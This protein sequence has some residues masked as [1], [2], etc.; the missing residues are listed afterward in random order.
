MRGTAPARPR[1]GQVVRGCRRGRWSRSGSA[2]ILLL[3]CPVSAWTPAPAALPV[4]TEIEIVPSVV[5][6]AKG[7]QATRFVLEARL[8]TLLWNKR[9]GIPESAGV[10]VSWSISP[11]GAG[12]HLI[13]NPHGYHAT[14]ELDPGVDLA[15]TVIVKAQA[16]GLGADSRIVPAGTPGEDLV[17]T[18]YT[19]DMAADAVVVRGVKGSQPC[20]MWLAPGLSR[21]GNAGDVTAN[22]DGDSWGVALLDPVHAVSMYDA[23]WTPGVDQVDATGPSGVHSIPAAVR[24]FI[25]GTDSDLATRQANAQSFMLAEMD[26]A[27]TVFK[28]SRVGIQV[29]PVDVQIVPAPVSGD[30]TSVLNCTLGDVQT[31]IH[32]YFPPAAPVGTPPLLHVYV[33]DE[34]GGSDGFAC[35]ATSRRPFPVIYLREAQHSGTIL[36]HELGHVLGLDLPGAGHSDDM[37]QFDAANV[38]VSGY[39]TDKVWRRRLTVGQVVRMNAEA[40][41][42]LNWATDLNGNQLR[43]GAQPRL[44]C[45]CGVHD[46]AGRCPRLVDDIANPRGSVSTLQAWDCSDMVRVATAGAADDPGALLAGRRWGSPLTDCRFF[47]GTRWPIAGVEFIQSQNLTGPGLCP[48]WVAIFF[49]NHQPVFS[50]LANVGGAWSDA[51]DWR[52]LDPPL[53]AR[54]AVRFHVHYAPADASKVQ[55]DIAVAEQVYG[56]RNRTG[57]DLI[58]KPEEDV[59]GTA[60]PPCPPAPPGEFS[61]CYPPAGGATVTQLVGRVLGLQ[62]L[63]TIEQGWAAFLSNAFQV[64][65][66]KGTKLTLGQV[67]R[68]HST[69]RTPGFPNCKLTP[70]I[71]P[72][73]GADVG[74]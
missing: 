53:T 1:P 37:D 43:D 39:A 20:A 32:D 56:P 72:P 65:L 5:A 34:M 67:F 16:G 50:D 51:A 59:T 11:S 25:G 46:P 17:N 10:N 3:A 58:L 8:W 31:S 7:V 2:A 27:D 9:S 48:S 12:L 18:L 44:A 35:P 23:H 40:G 70:S 28:Y 24:V 62:D 52:P 57:L 42:W 13:G 33:V 60:F 74:P 49:R 69:L 14:L 26:D 73:L 55:A 71:C 61:V 64:A 4:V 54:Q 30:E 21:T 63:T 41:S 22:C 29:D 15:G 36:V 38:M 19:D 47:R 45:Q 68:I 66:R 6:I